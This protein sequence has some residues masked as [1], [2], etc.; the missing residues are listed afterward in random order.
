MAT[1]LTELNIDFCKQMCYT[2]NAGPNPSL[3]AGVGPAFQLDFVTLWSNNP[4]R[5]S[6]I[7]L[8]V[9]YGFQ[10]EKRLVDTILGL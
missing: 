5:I 8:L 10:R 2:N 3:V 1:Y 4:V 9:E 7:S 6:L